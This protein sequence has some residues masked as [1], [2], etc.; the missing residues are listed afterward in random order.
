MK[1]KINNK[2]VLI[3]ILDFLGLANDKYPTNSRQSNVAVFIKDIENKKGMPLRNLLNEK[4]V[5]V[6]IPCKM[7]DMIATS[8][9]GKASLL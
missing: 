1:R 6:N 3:S 8:V 4:R 5:F 7:P 9:R 2:D